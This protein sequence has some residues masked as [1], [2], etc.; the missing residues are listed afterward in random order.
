MQFLQGASKGRT[1]PILTKEGGSLRYCLIEDQA[2]VEI[3]LGER[4]SFGRIPD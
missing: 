1:T 4:L 2:K 3:Q